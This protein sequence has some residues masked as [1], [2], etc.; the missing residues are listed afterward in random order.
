[1][2]IVNRPTKLKPQDIPNYLHIFI[3]PSPIPAAINT[4]ISCI[5]KKFTV[6]SEE[7]EKTYR[8]EVRIMIGELCENF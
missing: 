3:F 7:K 1:M 8:A 5:Q 4:D 6:L 2:L